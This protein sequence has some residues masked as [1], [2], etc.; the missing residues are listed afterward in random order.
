[1]AT[2][3]PD[4][5][6]GV[7]LAIND[8]PFANDGLLGWDSIK[9]WISDYVNHYYD[10]PSLVKSDAELQSWWTEIRT[11]G[12]A[13]KKDAPW[14]PKLDTTEDLVGILTTIIW[15]AS[16]H[17]AAVNFGQYAYAGYFPNRP[18][19]ARTNMPTEDPSED[20][21]RFFQERVQ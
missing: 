4:A 9:E 3:D 5:P 6:H 11:E 21:W 10:S 14:W 2:E 1:M 15:V 8:Y 19:I 13:D 16:A 18:T 17:H 12:H 7:K 20:E